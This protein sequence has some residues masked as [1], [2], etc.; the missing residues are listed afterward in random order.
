[1]AKTEKTIRQTVTLKS[2]RGPVVTVLESNAEAFTKAGYKPVKAP[3]TTPA[4][5]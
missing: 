3:S 5:K 2:P 1:M 4:G